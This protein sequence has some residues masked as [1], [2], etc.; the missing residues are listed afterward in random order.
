M[1]TPTTVKI[2]DATV[3]FKKTATLHSIHLGMKYLVILC[4]YSDQQIKIKLCLS[5]IGS[6]QPAVDF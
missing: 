2:L 5:R 1:I 4:L 6:T 3:L